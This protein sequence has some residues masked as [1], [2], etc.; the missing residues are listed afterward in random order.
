MK[1]ETIINP[2]KRLPP[3]IKNT[4]QSTVVNCVAAFSFSLLP[5]R[6][7]HQGSSGGIKN[8]TT[9]KK[10][11]WN[12]TFIIAPARVKNYKHISFK[13]QIHQPSSGPIRLA[14]CRHGSSSEFLTKYYGLNE[15]ILCIFFGAI[16]PSTSTKRN[17]PVTHF[18]T[19]C[20]YVFV[21]V[22]LFTTHCCVV[23]FQP[24]KGVSCLPCHRLTWSPLTASSSPLWDCSSSSIIII[25]SWY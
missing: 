21:W 16:R 13:P 7:C 12:I 8:Y 19:L 4:A 1:Y 20:T 6:C 18:S 22:W 9:Y 2:S 10:V 3:R 25:L 24:K 5:T 23:Q 17:F 11:R 15:T 14:S